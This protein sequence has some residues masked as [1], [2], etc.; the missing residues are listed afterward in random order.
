MVEKDDIHSLLQTGS[1]RTSRSKSPTPYDSHRRAYEPP[2]SNIGVPRSAEPQPYDKRPPRPSVEDEEESLAREHVGS[3]VSITSDE[4]PKYRGDIDQQPILL[5][6]H[7]HNPERRFVIVPNAGNGD[8]PN[9]NLPEHSAPKEQY[10]ANTCRK[11]VLVTPGKTEDEGIEDKEAPEHARDEKKR[12]DLPKRKSH[13]DLPRLSTQFEQPEP[14]IRRSGSRRVRE[15]VVVDQESQNRPKPRDTGT[16]RNPD[17]A[18]LSPAT[19]RQTA[20]KRDRAYWDFSKETS[21]NSNRSSSSRAA[22]GV[23]APERKRPSHSASGLSSNPTVHKRASSTTN[24]P[25]RDG[26]PPER[27]RSFI[28]PCGYG[29]PDEIFAFMAPG[30]DFI[31]GRPSRDESPRR[32]RN[33]DSPPYP[34]GAREMPGRSPNRRHKPRSGA[35]ERDG[36]SSDEGYRERRPNRAEHAYP[37]RSVVESEYPSL[38]QADQ[39]RQPP[40]KLEPPFPSLGPA[41]SGQAGDNS[42]VPSPRSATF[43]TDKSRRQ[44]ERSLSR[45]PPTSTSP[46]RRPPRGSREPQ[47]NLRSRGDSVS[48]VSNGSV[49]L[50]PSVPG[51]L[52]RT[53][54]AERKPLAG[55]AAS[56]VRHQSSEL[57]SPAPYWQT[58]RTEERSDTEQRTT[59]SIARYPEEALKGAFPQLPDCR[60]RRPT[61]ARNVTSSDKFRTLKRAENFTIC[62]D[63]Y[64]AVFAN[65]DFRHQFGPSPARPSDQLISCDFGSSHWYRIAF[66][67][68]LKHGYPDLRL[69]Q[70]VASVDARC[71]PCGGNQVATRIW[72]SMMGPNSRHPIHTFNVC[73]GCAK[74]VEALLPNLAG[75]FVPLDSH[76]PSKDICELHFTPE[77]KRFWE[78]FELM[79]TTSDEALR[80]RTA[81]DIAELADRIR[82]LS[83]IEECLRNT[84]V[85]NRTWHVMQQIPEFTVCE[86]CFDAVVWPIIENEDSDV[87]RNFYKGRQ[88]RPLAACQ[89]YSKRMR[90][91]FR[92][93]SQYNDFN[94]LASHVRERLRALAEI[95]ARYNE[96]LREDQEDPD[97][98]EELAVLAARFKEVE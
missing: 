26:P 6:V 78:Y 2:K 96:L 23:E 7:E 67:M 17:D 61:P 89:L 80:H 57:K 18:F 98:Q 50:P 91:V 72:Y 24:M 70:G 58:S 1:W 93:A 47:Y 35:R 4:E 43:P 56:L 39:A 44:D 52:S 88:P 40:S 95:K 11:Y 36:Y 73:L 60:W 41:H 3:I 49:S 21:G 8:A 68:T 54:A 79:E 32:T 66:L 76:E 10:E 30:D 62:P 51:S 63:C 45:S 55:P 29:D 85:P 69:L 38:T 46:T 94:Y 64:E 37:A 31:A 33:G 27:P 13:Q 16:T 82:E 81:P 83:L 14:S 22:A 25:V 12:A 86:A 20:G 74:T 75:A 34:R 65:T 19:V 42:L 71:Q 53:S 48:T 97:V 9:T 5:E 77:R 15:D 84:P 59:A 90:E 87:P 28:Q 92:L